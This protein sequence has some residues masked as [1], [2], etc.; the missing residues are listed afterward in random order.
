MKYKVET[1]NK[2]HIASINKDVIEAELK[3]EAG[4]ITPKVQIW[5][6]FPGFETITFGSEVEGDIKTSTKGNFT[7]TT[8]YAPQRS[9]VGNYAQKKSSDIKTAMVQKEKSIEKFQDNKEQ[10]IQKASVMRD[11]T[12]LAIAEVG[13][14]GVEKDILEAKWESWQKWLTGKW[15]QPF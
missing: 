13:R 11:A 3:D 5:Q 6:T 9:A 8:L 10:S 2:K 14:D 1:L 15:E 12:L 7:N 4:L